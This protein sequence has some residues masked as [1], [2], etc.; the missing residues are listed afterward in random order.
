MKL[1]DHPILSLICA[2][3]THKSL[4][5]SLRRMLAFHSANGPVS[6]VKG[7]LGGMISRWL[8][9]TGLLTYEGWSEVLPS[10]K[11]I[12]GNTGRTRYPS[13][14]ME[15]YKAS[16]PGP[17]HHLKGQRRWGKRMLET[18]ELM[19]TV[20]GDGTC[21]SM[22]WELGRFARQVGEAMLLD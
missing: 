10:N 14:T 6:P 18:C 2:P 7:T 8:R 20:H 15:S 5:S 22:F 3:C 1:R 9:S 11:W 19:R 4:Q 12:E 16:T 17:S 21:L 13:Q